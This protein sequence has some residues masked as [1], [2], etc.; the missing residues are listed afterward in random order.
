MILPILLKSLKQ[1]CP[2]TAS[3]KQVSFAVFA[4]FALFALKSFIQNTT[5]IFALFALK[6]FIQNT[7][8]TASTKQDPF[9]VFTFHV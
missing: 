7:T 4:I 9:A 8:N 2:G 1:P 5:K 6:S 3:T